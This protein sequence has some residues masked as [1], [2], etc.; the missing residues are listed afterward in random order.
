MVSHEYLGRCARCAML[1]TVLSL[2]TMAVTCYTN[3]QADAQTSSAKREVYTTLTCGYPNP[4]QNNAN[5]YLKT[6][7][8]IANKS[9]SETMRGRRERGIEQTIVLQGR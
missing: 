4:E 7:G 2:T 9:N 3:K 6:T 5:K 1:E 8:N